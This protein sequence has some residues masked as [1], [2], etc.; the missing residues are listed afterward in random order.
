M[1]FFLNWFLCNKIK[2][3]GQSSASPW[4]VAVF[5]AVT[6][7][8]Q[9]L[10]VQG[11]LLFKVFCVFP[12]FS[13]LNSTQVFVSQF[14]SFSLFSSFFCVFLT[15]LSLSSVCG[16][17]NMSEYAEPL[18]LERLICQLISFSSVA[19]NLMSLTGTIGHSW[20]KAITPWGI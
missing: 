11:G 20:P 9:L 8:Q 5:V 13:C 18:Y 15:V 2:Y 19:A 16:Q 1:D 17:S 3:V 7:L 12:A 10:L 4:Q 14:N 6:F